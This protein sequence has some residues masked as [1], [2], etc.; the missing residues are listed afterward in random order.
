MLGRVQI[1][2]FGFLALRRHGISSRLPQ[3]YTWSARQ[4][5]GCSGAVPA[6]VNVSSFK[7]SQ[8]PQENE[9]C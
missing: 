2:V 4:G 1:H 6:V 8:D 9:M 5:V 3:S 7:L